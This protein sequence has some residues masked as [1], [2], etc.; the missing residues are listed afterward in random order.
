MERIGLG[1]RILYLGFKLYKKKLYRQ[2]LNI[3]ILYL[4]YSRN[5]ILNSCINDLCS[6]EMKKM[7]EEGWDCVSS[8]ICCSVSEHVD[9]ETSNL[10]ILYLLGKGINFSLFLIIFIY[11]LPLPRPFS[12]FSRNLAFWKESLR[13][14]VFEQFLW[15]RKKRWMWVNVEWC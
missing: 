12:W 1:A 5:I 7:F 11:T 9:V 4:D 8:I 13:Q 3:L 15:N 6:E 2:V 10:V 14:H